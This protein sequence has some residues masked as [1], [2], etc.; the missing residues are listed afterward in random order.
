MSIHVN[1]RRDAE[2]GGGRRS[3]AI[4]VVSSG[5]S[6]RS[7]TYLRYPICDARPGVQSQQLG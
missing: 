5:T 3:C 7:P 1:D 2:A 6:F 4:Q